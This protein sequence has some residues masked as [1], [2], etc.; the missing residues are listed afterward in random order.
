MTPFIYL[1]MCRVFHELRVFFFIENRVIRI[2]PNTNLM[3]P[4]H[5]PDD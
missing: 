4:K 3:K 1:F 5:T 2:V